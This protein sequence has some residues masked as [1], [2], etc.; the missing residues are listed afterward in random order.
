MQTQARLNVD[1]PLP[2]ERV[3]RYQ[4]MQD[5]LHQL[6]N[7]PFE[8][9]TQR[10]LAS[11]TG[12]DVSTVSRSV[13]L[14]DQLGVL[15]IE[16]GKPARIRI[17]HDHLQRD[18]P[19]FAIPQPEF[20]PPIAAFLDTL[21]DRIETS[22]TVSELLGVVL[23]GSVARGTADRRSDID[24]LVLVDGDDT[25]ARRIATTVAGE[26]ES[27]SFDG[28]RY[29]FEV[30]AETPAS[31]ASYGSKL[32]DIFDSGIV[33]ESTAEL[34]AVRETIYEAERGKD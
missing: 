15:D 4:A 1:I 16:P 26:I 27:Q 11:V 28:D 6:V 22:E 7:S 30:L 23:F 8:R 12:A 5:I 29:A 31:A 21:V 25:H 9:F 19:L 24:L 13:D 2:D 10:E 3:F 17:N 20:R 33:L 18:D 32:A 14:L 34:A